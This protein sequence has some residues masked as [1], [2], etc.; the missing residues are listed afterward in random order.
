[1]IATLARLGFAPP[2]AIPITASAGVT[3]IGPSLDETIKRAELALFAARPRAE[4][5]WNALPCR[6][7]DPSAELLSQSLLQR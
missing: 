3:P 7:N 6:S 2:G 4:T 1:M 5:A